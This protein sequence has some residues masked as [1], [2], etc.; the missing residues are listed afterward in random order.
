MNNKE[1]RSR[2]WN[3]KYRRNQQLYDEFE[4]YLSDHRSK[5]NP[6]MRPADF[7]THEE[8]Y[9]HVTIPVENFDDFNEDDVRY[10]KKFKPGTDFV[11]RPNE[12]D[13]GFFA[14]AYLPFPKSKSSPRRGDDLDE[15]PSQGK[16]PNTLVPQAILFGYMILAFVTVWKTSLSDWQFIFH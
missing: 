14:V 11:C 6:K 10:I 9:D 1:K 8:A 13:T 3:D 4:A 16:G 5:R 15:A 2:E 7:S 12:K